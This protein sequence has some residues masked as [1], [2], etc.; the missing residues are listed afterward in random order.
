MFAAGVP[1]VVHSLEITQHTFEGNTACMVIACYACM[2]FLS[3]CYDNLRFTNDHDCCPSVSTLIKVIQLGCKDWIK[4]AH[5]KKLTHE[6][7]K[8][9]RGFMDPRQ[10]LLYF[11]QIAAK[12]ELVK[13]YV[14][15]NSRIQYSNWVMKPFGFKSTLEILNK[16]R[17]LCL[18]MS[19]SAEEDDNYNPVVSIWVRDGVCFVLSLDKH[20]N[21]WIFDSHQRDPVYGTAHEED[22]TAVLVEF[23]NTEAVLDFLE[24]KYGSFTLPSSEDVSE[25]EILK[26]AM[27]EQIAVYFMSFTNPEEEEEEDQAQ[28]EQQQEIIELD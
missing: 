2:Y 11:P 4:K 8:A 25:E 12:L 9:V 26:R 1:W 27:K 20:A 14:C 5:S 7:R 21:A 3:T 19:D 22:G 6:Q 24:L 28:D 13:E 15:V 23:E 16:M 18:S 10:T 17:E